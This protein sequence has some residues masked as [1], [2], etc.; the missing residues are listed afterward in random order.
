M[1]TTVPITVSEP[2]PAI[3]NVPLG[4]SS[5]TSTAASVTGA[6]VGVNVEEPA[7]IRGAEAEAS[8]YAVP[9]RVAVTVVD[10]MTS[11]RVMIA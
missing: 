7:I 6:A 11:V 4:K 10:C 9:V 3:A 2:V 8:G 1:P 5:V